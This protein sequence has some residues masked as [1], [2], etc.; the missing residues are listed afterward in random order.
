MNGQG[1]DGVLYS[2]KVVLRKAIPLMEP[3]SR[4]KVTDPGWKDKTDGDVTEPRYRF[5]SKTLH[6]QRIAS[7]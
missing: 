7:S 2:F 3:I 1:T 4:R 5:T 6:T